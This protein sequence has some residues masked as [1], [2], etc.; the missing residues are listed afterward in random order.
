[1]TAADYVYA[2]KRHYDPQF[3]S[4]NLFQ[5]ETAK[6]LGQANLRCAHANVAA[7]FRGGEQCREPARLG[8]G[9]VI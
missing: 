4:P 3:K 9:V 5:F 1:M 6:V 7:R 2:V 8:Y